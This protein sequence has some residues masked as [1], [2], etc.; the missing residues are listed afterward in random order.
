LGSG[1]IGLIERGAD[2]AL[3]IAGTGIAARSADGSADDDGRELTAAEEALPSVPLASAQPADP[4][5]V[6]ARRLAAAR[7]MG[8]S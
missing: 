6:A 5:R 1:V 8:T 4:S 3:G 7:V 2:E